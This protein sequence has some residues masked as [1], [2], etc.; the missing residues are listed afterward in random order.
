MAK[1]ISSSQI[2]PSPDSLCNLLDGKSTWQVLL[3]T[4]SFLML[5]REH[6]EALPTRQGTW[7]KPK[8]LIYC[9]LTK[10]LCLKWPT[11]DEQHCWQPQ[12]RAHNGSTIE[13]LCFEPLFGC[14]SPA[15]KLSCCNPSSFQGYC[16]LSS[17]L[18]FW[19]HGWRSLII[20]N[21]ER[22]EL[23]RSTLNIKGTW[24]HRHKDKSLCTNTFWV[25][26]NFPER[27]HSMQT[28]VYTSFQKAADSYLILQRP[29]AYPQSH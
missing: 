1:S 10:I 6:K 4:V 9:G 19:H 13:N 23:R 17:P 24:Y 8:L 3:N 22:A 28:H 14:I 25:V 12:D 26:L 5:P 15:V 2:H 27:K 21:S 16:V 20:W 11:E 29:D 18:N 7:W